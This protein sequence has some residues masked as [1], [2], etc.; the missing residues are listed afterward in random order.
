MLGSDGRAASWER[1]AGERGET[2]DGLAVGLLCLLCKLCRLYSP[3]SLVFEGKETKKEK[4]TSRR[5]SARVATTNSAHEATSSTPAAV[6]SQT[7]VRSKRARSIDSGSSYERSGETFL[8]GGGG[9]MEKAWSV[10]SMFY[11]SSV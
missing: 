10:P 7:N 4:L 8:A 3:H 9:K 1:D 6:R 2:L 11:C 5:Q